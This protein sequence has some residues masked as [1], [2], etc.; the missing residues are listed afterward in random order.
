MT[1][2]RSLTHG[3]KWIFKGEIGVLLMS[4]INVKNGLSLVKLKVF[5]IVDWLKDTLCL[6]I[7]GFKQPSRHIALFVSLKDI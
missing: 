4:M 7:K 1:N 2:T 5:K 3:Q 6:H